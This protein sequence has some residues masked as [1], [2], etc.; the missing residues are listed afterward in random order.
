MKPEGGAL[1][2][3]SNRLGEWQVEEADCGMAIDIAR[4]GAIKTYIGDIKP[5]S[6][7]FTLPTDWPTLHA[8]INSSG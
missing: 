5:G 3:I 4:I 7:F 1:G 6:S 8:A 2:S